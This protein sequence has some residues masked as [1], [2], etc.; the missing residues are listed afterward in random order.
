[1]H[2]GRRP[3]I[4]LALAAGVVGTWLAIPSAAAPVETPVTRTAALASPAL[5]ASPSATPTQTAP[6]RATS[7]PPTSSASPPS[8]AAPRTPAELV[9]VRPPSIPHRGVTTATPLLRAALDAKLAAI[10]AR[11]GIPGISAAIVFP[12]GTTWRGV[13]GMADVAAARAVTPDTAF[14]VASVSKTFTAAVI[15]G[16]VQEGRLSLDTSARSYL[17]T[18]P[19]DPAITI[20]EL[21]DHTSG[22]R[23]FFFG[24]GVDHALLSKPARVWDPARSLKYLGKPFSKPGVS[25]HYSNT[26]FLVLGMIAQAVGHAT[27]ADQL[28]ARFLGPLGLEHTYY[29][30][31]EQPRGPVV[32]D[33]RFLGTSPKLPAI[34]L[35]DG[36]AV[37]PFTSVVTAAGAAG[38]IATTATDL[39]HWAQALYAGPALDR[40]TRDAMLDDALRTA[41]LKAA[42][43]YGLGV[44][45][46]LVDGVPTLGHSGRYLGARAVFRW[47][48]NQRIAIAVL[49]NQ[50]RTDVNP[51]AASLLKIALTPQRDCTTCANLP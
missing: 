36:T 24:A 7:S 37:V 29:Q 18:L 51:I 27:V 43:G 42:I 5:I 2:P 38:S 30:Q 31:V 48:P 40:P 22:L 10:R 26:N 34:D 11:T 33:Y 46:V 35:S 47:L 49:T 12:D 19:I 28:R 6:I 23:D 16:L 14:P 15:M 44:Q 20:R 21:L 13:G 39:A 1:M 3:V 32:H 4:A 50:S 8:S 45:E 17:P 41:K 25:W 9:G